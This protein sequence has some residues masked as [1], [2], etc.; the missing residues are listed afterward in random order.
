ML[1]RYRGKGRYFL[2]P[3]I[4]GVLAVASMAANLASLSCYG[5]HGCNSWGLALAPPALYLLILAV[6]SFLIL[7]VTLK[8][9]RPIDN[10]A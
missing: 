6:G 3:L 2:F 5:F 7:L 8:P 10:S 1:G 9:A 4:C